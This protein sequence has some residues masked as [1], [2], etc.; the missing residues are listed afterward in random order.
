MKK[1]L[2]ISLLTISAAVVSCKKEDQTEEEYEPAAVPTFT[3]DTPIENQS[4]AYGDTIKI[5][6]TITSETDMHGYNVRLIDLS[7]N[8][9]LVDKVYHE[10]GNSFT[11]S[12]SKKIT[13]SDTTQ[14]T[15]IIDAAID[16]EGNIATKSRSITCYPQ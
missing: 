16:H 14:M 12:E 6:G 8:M 4:F 15:I 11:F 1:L 9:N 7:T 3:I 13:V 10:H 2:Y 5:T